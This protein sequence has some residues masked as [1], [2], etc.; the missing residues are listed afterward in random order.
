[1]VLSNDLDDAYEAYAFIRVFTVDFAFLEERRADLVAGETFTVAYLNSQPTAGQ[2]QYGFTIKGRNA[3]PRPEA[4]A[5]YDA[6]G[7]IVIG[8]TEACELTLTNDYNGEASLDGESFSA[9][10][11]PYTINWT[12]EDA[13][14]NTATCSTTITVVDE[15]APAF[16]YCPEDIEQDALSGNCLSLVSWAEPTLD[17]VSD[18]CGVAS[19]VG[20]LVSDS[21]VQ[22]VPQSNGNAFGNFP[23]G[24][25]TVSY[26]VTDVNGNS[27]VCEFTVTV[28]DNEAPLLF[29]FEDFYDMP[30]DPLYCGALVD[31]EPPIAFDQCGDLTYFCDYTGTDSGLDVYPAGEDTEVTWTI[32]DEAGNS[33]SVTATVRVAKIGPASN[34]QAICRPDKNFV[35][36]KFDAADGADR[37][38]IQVRAAGGGPFLWVDRNYNANVTVAYL[39]LDSLPTGAYEWRVVSLCKMD[40]AENLPGWTEYTKRYTKW[41]D[42]DLPCDGSTIMPDGGLDET[43]ANKLGETTLFD[44]EIFPNPNTGVFN[45]R[46]D[47]EMYNLDIM[48]AEGSVV[49]HMERITDQFM[50]MNLDGLNNGIY[51]VRFYNDATVITKRV[52]IQK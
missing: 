41:M 4:D 22:I 28:N 13:A 40:D 5:A 14:G 9:T 50:E 38:L 26:I 24:E 7:S 23:I 6:L 39:P 17:D 25:T 51:L 31:V 42:L 15:E 30:F 10:D 12:V 48:D 52:T 34:L 33:V 46:T 3:D 35:K 36:L 37:Y 18:N 11:S 21:T 47:L 19:L 43:S 8:A 1:E 27:S 45:I 2:I 49:Y 16:S 29:D 20:P 44:A 32:T